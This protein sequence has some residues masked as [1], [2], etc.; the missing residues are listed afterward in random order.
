LKITQSIL[1]VYFELVVFISS[2]ELRKKLV[3]ELEN[4]KYKLLDSN[5]IAK[6]RYNLK[7]DDL[8]KN[9]TNF[10]YKDDLKLNFDR[11]YKLQKLLSGPIHSK[12]ILK[13]MNNRIVK[14]NQITQ[15]E[16]DVLLERFFD[17]NIERL[18]DRKTYFSGAI[19]LFSIPSKI[20][21][22]FDNYLNE[23]GKK[24]LPKRLVKSLENIYPFW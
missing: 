23:K 13:A 19:K 18:D 22:L 15:S 16:L 24:V 21:F 12:A 5:K 4:G 2:K 17:L 8:I 9:N 14:E 10:G 3:V 6:L 7:L 1:R 11:I 20:R